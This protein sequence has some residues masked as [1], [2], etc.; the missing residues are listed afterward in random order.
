M[1]A[2][3]RTGLRKVYEDTTNTVCKEMKEI[4]K[5]LDKMSKNLNAYYEYVDTIFDKGGHSFS[6]T[7]AKLLKYTNDA[8][9]EIPTIDE[10]VKRIKE[11]VGCR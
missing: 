4:N 3:K 10:S 5:A 7:D 1:P 11:T 8:N 6:T 2:A 9:G